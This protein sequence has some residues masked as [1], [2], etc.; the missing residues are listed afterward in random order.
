MTR[1]KN[2]LLIFNGNSS[3]ISMEL[4][5]ILLNGAHF[6]AVCVTDNTNPNQL[7]FSLP[8]VTLDMWEALNFRFIIFYHVNETLHWFIA[9]WKDFLPASIYS[10]AFFQSAVLCH[11][12]SSTQLFHPAE[13]FHFKNNKTANCFINF[14]IC[15]VRTERR[16]GGNI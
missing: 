4:K 7:V 3:V 16:T 11:V 8:D 10:W 6:K 1:R 12:Y 14:S 2:A 5:W 15:W 13:S 9:C